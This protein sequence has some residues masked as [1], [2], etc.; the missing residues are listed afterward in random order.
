[1]SNYPNKIDGSVELPVLRNNITEATADT[2]N[3]LR[4]AI[5]N[6]ERALGIKPNG[7]RA[8][9]SKRLSVSIDDNG[10]LKESALANLNV[11]SGKIND[12]DVAISARISESKLDL[13]YSTYYLKSEILAIEKDVEHIIDSVSQYISLLKLHLDKNYLSAH[14][15]LQVDLKNSINAP[16]ATTLKQIQDEDLQSAVQ[17]IYDEHIN[18]KKEFISDSSNSH[19]AEQISYSNSAINSETLFSV[20][21]A[22]D[23]LISKNSLNR[24]GDLSE[25]SE[26]G[27]LLEGRTYDETSR[28]EEKILVSEKEVFYD[29]KSDFDLELSLVSSQIIKDIEVG[30]LVY[31]SNANSASEEVLTITKVNYLDRSTEDVL[32]VFVKNNVSVG[33]ASPSN[34]SITKNKRSEYNKNSLISSFRSYSGNSI[35]SSIYIENPNAASI[36]SSGFLTP[37]VA[38]KNLKISYEGGSI[39]V[40]VFDSSYNSIE[41]VISALNTNFCDGLVPLSASKVIIENRAELC[42]SH[43]LPNYSLLSNKPFIS[44]S[45]A[46]SD[47]FLDRSGFKYMEGESIFGINGS[48]SIVNGS[49]LKDLFLPLDVTAFVGILSGSSQMTVLSDNVILSKI[50]NRNLLYVENEGAHIGLFDV[51]SV[52][53][54]QIYFQ[55]ELPFGFDKN[56]STKVFLLKNTVS[57]E[58][59]SYESAASSEKSMLIEILLSERG[60]VVTHKT[61]EVFNS[62]TSTTA[63][64]FIPQMRLVDLNIKNKGGK[65]YLLSYSSDKYLSANRGSLVG[66]KVFAP[67][68]GDYKVPSP[69][70]DG[71]LLVNIVSNEESPSS[72][73]S[74]TIKAFKDPSIGLMSLSSVLFS[75]NLR[76]YSAPSSYGNVNI[77]SSYDKRNIGVVGSKQISSDFKAKELNLPRSE[78]ET[79]RVMSGMSLSGTLSISSGTYTIEY[80]ISSGVCYVNG[81]RIFSKEQSASGSFEY[82]SKAIIYIE[83][84]GEIGF[85]VSENKFKKPLPK[86]YLILYTSDIESKTFSRTENT[87]TTF[88]K[89]FKLTS[90]GRDGL[91]EITVGNNGNFKNLVEA[92]HFLEAAYDMVEERISARILLEN[93]PHELST[94]IK[95]GN[96]SISLVGGGDN[97]S[98]AI[99]DNL[100][101]LNSPDDPIDTGGIDL[102]SSCFQIKYT[103]NSN[104]IVNIEFKN[105]KFDYTSILYT[106]VY[107]IVSIARSTNFSGKK[108]INFEGCSFLGSESFSNSIATG[109]ST[110]IP[111]Y[112]NPDFTANGPGDLNYLGDLTVRGCYFRKVGSKPQSGPILFVRTRGPYDYSV[113]NVIFSNNIFENCS[114]GNDLS[115][116][117]NTNNINDIASSPIVFSLEKNF[118]FTGNMIYGGL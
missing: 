102:N 95:L 43:I 3:R 99:S 83:S 39:E 32:S 84:S 36:V 51:K 118:I 67:I 68:S 58:S 111:F 94:S 55:K 13:D 112:M 65:E 69:D 30:D 117:C 91:R 41:Y 81:R 62:P 42:I 79:N 23:Y 104:L 63:S 57:S 12:S 60:D 80:T 108:I 26:S 16:S 85:A 28:Y 98:V 74:L 8:S 96:Y 71:H 109:Y 17:R 24:D 20:K 87:S 75:D 37:T 93:H 101:S 107:S 34:I 59:I 113:D 70:S 88:K 35:N 90:E 5:I 105:I 72:G 106:G 9:L 4:T 115:P 2:I 64:G 116:F 25:I 86:D 49:I 15:A 18:L 50:R 52:I 110:I 82:G 38:E 100:A 1:M 61:A 73:I 76:Y 14:N 22:L 27:T 89:S 46:S 21:Q 53:N 56:S 47:D 48:S 45:A 7:N 77:S 33:Y 97:C 92:I 54:N 114:S 29:N 44:M 103:D 40:D 11:I 66:K 6:I 10:D 31:L 19:I 78:N